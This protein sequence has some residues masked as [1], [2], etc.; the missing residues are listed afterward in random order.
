MELR[1]RKRV[2]RIRSAKGWREEDLTS[3]LLEVPRTATSLCFSFKTFATDPGVFVVTGR[4]G[5]PV[6]S[7]VPEVSRVSQDGRIN[8]MGE[9]GK[10]ADS[11]KFY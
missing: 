4:Q 1:K 3:L 11:R 10:L 7:G 5:G 6:V 9:G 2:F 8:G